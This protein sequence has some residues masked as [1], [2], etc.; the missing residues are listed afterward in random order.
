MLGP[1]EYGCILVREI[2]EFN[3]RPVIGGLPAFTRCHKLLCIGRNEPISPSA[4]MMMPQVRCCGEMG[5][6]AAIALI[7]HGHHLE[8]N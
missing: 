1:R 4:A 6:C 8:A 7:H 2:I 3:V 5:I